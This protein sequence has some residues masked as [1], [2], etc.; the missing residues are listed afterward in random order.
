MTRKR[1]ID[2]QIS[3]KEKLAITRKKDRSLDTLDS[4]EDRRIREYLNK[5]VTWAKIGDTSVSR[6]LQRCESPREKKRRLA[7]EK[8]KGNDN[9]KSV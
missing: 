5:A 2:H 9:D 1:I 7:N 4:P 6:L 3:G 8:L